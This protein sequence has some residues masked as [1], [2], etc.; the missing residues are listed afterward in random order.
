M[1]KHVPW[2]FDMF[3]FEPG[4]QVPEM[5]KATI[6][7]EVPNNQVGSAMGGRWEDVSGFHG[8]LMEI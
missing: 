5:P 7:T 2:S 3:G 1:L 4:F 8:D 6:T